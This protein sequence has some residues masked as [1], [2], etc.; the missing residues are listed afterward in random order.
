MAE[1][2]S[3][4]KPPRRSA[5]RDEGHA[6]LL[7]TIK[8][9]DAL[10]LSARRHAAI[11]WLRGERAI[12]SFRRIATCHFPIFQRTEIQKTRNWDERQPLNNA[13]ANVQRH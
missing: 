4:V 3:H 7:L 11:T 6:T 9:C 12:F 10:H 13:L 2:I 1:P 8:Q 5:K